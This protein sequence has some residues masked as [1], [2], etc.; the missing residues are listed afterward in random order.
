MPNPTISK[1]LEGWR[2]SSRSKL[3]E[4]LKAHHEVGG[5]GRGRRYATE[6]I[7]HAYLVAVSA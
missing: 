1:E 6:Q 3:D 2:T 5:G 7:N 4:L